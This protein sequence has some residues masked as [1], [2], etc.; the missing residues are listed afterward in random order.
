MYSLLIYSHPLT[1]TSAMSHLHPG[2]FAA[3]GDLGAPGS[4]MDSRY[5]EMIKPWAMTKHQTN[6]W[7][8]HQLHVFQMFKHVQIKNF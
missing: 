7:D 1:Q 6:S 3:H 2:F 5:P 8:S 4:G